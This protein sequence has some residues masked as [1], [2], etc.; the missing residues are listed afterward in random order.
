MEKQCQND[1]PQPPSYSPP[2]VGPSPTIIATETT[3]EPQQ[4]RAER[5]EKTAVVSHSNATDSVVPAEAPS[6]SVPVLEGPRVVS[7]EQLNDMPQW[8]DC[9]FCHYRATTKVVEHDSS[10][11]K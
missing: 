11:T 7:L 8:I 9:P 3:A 10:Q 2:E 6:K 4:T 5:P 1:E